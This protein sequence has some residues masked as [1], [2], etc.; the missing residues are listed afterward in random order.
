ML[1]AVTVTNFK[2]ESLRMELSKPEETGLL[3]YNITG[4]AG[5]TASINS[6]DMATVDGGRFNSARAQT[7]NIVL[8]LAFVDPP[9]IKHHG[10]ESSR[11]KS[12]K[13]FPSKKPLTLYFE[14][15]ERIIVIDGYVENNDVSIFSKD[16]YAQISII[17]TD[18]YFRSVQ[19][20][21]LVFTSTDPSGGFEFPFENEMGKIEEGSNSSRIFSE[22]YGLDFSDGLS[23]RLTAS[24]PP[25]SY[26]FFI[27]ADTTIDYVL[28]ELN[29]PMFLA[30]EGYMFE[31]N[32]STGEIVCTQF[33]GK[34]NDVAITVD[35]NPLEP[36]R[37]VTYFVENHITMGEIKA[38]KVYNVVYPGDA[39]VGMKIIIQ[40]K[41]TARGIEIY[42]T[43]TRERMSIDDERLFQ[44]TGGYISADDIITISTIKGNK[45]ATLQRGIKLYNIINAIGKDS[46]WIQLT[47]GDNIVG[48]TA[49]NGIDFLSFKVEYDVLYEGV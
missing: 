17:C 49:T 5:P 42:N 16:E 3:I 22:I 8:T 9:E 11:H 14:T 32:E 47:Q 41:D 33:G 37:S 7:R 6:T 35:G 48:Y 18:P 21:E 25:D 31:Y 44:S 10:V 19:P 43:D 39:D 40:A 13:F 23:K 1:K 38:D 27:Y 4:I 20:T 45:Y 15:D 34:V 46:D 2:G 26:S 30:R 24:R 28:N 12:Y 29:D 36:A